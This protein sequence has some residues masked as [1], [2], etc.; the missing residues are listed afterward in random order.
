MFTPCKA[1]NVPVSCVCNSASRRDPE[2][3][4]T[5]IFD[6]YKGTFY[7]YKRYGDEVPQASVE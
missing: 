2:Q 6:L 3:H 1:F 5:F 4:L 7:M